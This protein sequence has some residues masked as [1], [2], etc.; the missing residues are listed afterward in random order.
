MLI[1]PNHRK[2]NSVKKMTKHLSIIL[3]ASALMSSSCSVA[4]F[5]IDSGAADHDIAI[6]AW[7]YERA[8]AQGSNMEAIKSEIIDI[9]YKMRNSEMY[10]RTASPDNLKYLDEVTSVVFGEEGKKVRKPSIGVGRDTSRKVTLTVDKGGGF[11]ERTKKHDVRKRTPQQRRSEERMVP[12]PRGAEQD[13]QSKFRYRHDTGK[14][15]KLQPGGKY[16]EL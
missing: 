14:V 7:N 11:S 3:M 1:C 8:A 13:Q 12:S 16:V 9:Q 15:E 4:R 5:P 10:R 6:L 2:R